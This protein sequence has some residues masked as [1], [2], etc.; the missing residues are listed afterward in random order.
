[1][2]ALYEWPLQTTW[3]AGGDGG[4][5]TEEVGQLLDGAFG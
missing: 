2:K 5:V 3:F 4:R 1:V